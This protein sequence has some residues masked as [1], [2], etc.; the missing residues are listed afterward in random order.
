MLNLS[1]I[2]LMSIDV[3]QPF[4]AADAL[5]ASKTWCDFKDVILLTDVRRHSGI[6]SHAAKFGIRVVNH[7]ESNRTAKLPGIARTFYPDYERAQLTE[8]DN[9]VGDASHVLYMEADAGVINPDAWNPFWF[10]YDYIGAPWPRCAEHGFPE[11]DGV[12]NAVGNTG[13]SLRSRKFC[14]A[15]V[16]CLAAHSSDQAYLLSDTWLCRTQRAWLER[17]HK[18][19]FAPADVAARFS[20]ENK[21]YTGQ[22][23]FH[24]KST[25]RMNG[26]NWP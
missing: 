10:S 16:S 9:Y 23:G 22:F 5:I 13:F 19:E 21:I 2:V 15:T 1:T 20:C 7:T 26:W 4:K 17:E 12:T 14:H 6:A 8:P 25:M 18:I 11:C 24:G 3:A